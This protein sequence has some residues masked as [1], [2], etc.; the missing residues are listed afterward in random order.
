MARI[1]HVLAG[2][3]WGGGTYVVRRLVE[4]LLKQ[5]HEVTLVSSH[6]QTA[7]RFEALGCEVVRHIPFRR[8]IHPVGDLAGALRLAAQLRLRGCDLLHTHTSKGGVVGRV[9]GRLAGVRRVVHHVHGFAFDP[10]FTLRRRLAF[11]AAVERAVAPLCDAMVFV[12]AAD[13]ETARRLHILRPGQEARVIY[14]GVDL[15]PDVPAP[16][17]TPNEP[18]RI[19]FVG[20]LAEQKGVDVLLEATAGLRAQRPWELVIVGDGP[21][22]SRLEKLAAALPPGACRFVGHSDDAARWIASADVVALPSRWEGHSISLLEAMAHGKAVAATAIQGNVETI[23]SGVDGVLAPPGDPH[24]LRAALRMLLD[25]PD[26]RR[27][28]GAAARLQV[29]TRF[30]ARSLVEGVLRLYEDLGVATPQRG[31]P[32]A[33]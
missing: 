23:H 2:S 9:A 14:N 20:R 29:A 26:L 32:C 1:W 22:R 19:V 18:D 25:N 7:E 31:V 28:L 5:G 3:G 21:L 6:P 13:L 27:R 12:N 4:A 8:E 30:S 24:S 10:V 11:Y 17:R 15:P 16:H 33:P